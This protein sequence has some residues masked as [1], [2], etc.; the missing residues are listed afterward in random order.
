MS[1]TTNSSSNSTLPQPWN[2]WIER[3][4]PDGLTQQRWLFGDYQRS[5][6]LREIA[7]LALFSAQIRLGLIAYQQL[8][9][10]TR[11]HK[12]LLGRDWSA[13][14]H[15]KKFVDLAVDIPLPEAVQ[16][17]ALQRFLQSYPPVIDP[18]IHL[19]SDRYWQHYYPHLPL[20][21]GGEDEEQQDHG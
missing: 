14:R 13:T 7:N 15:P 8:N 3:I 1:T 16:V 19:A 4:S 21:S 2:G 17:E 5:D 9:R 12:W 6:Q 11:R 18:N 20:R 10:P